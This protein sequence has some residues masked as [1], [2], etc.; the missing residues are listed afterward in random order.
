MEQEVEQLTRTLALVHPLVCAV[1]HFES[2]R[3][4]H[5]KTKEE[6]AERYNREQF[7][8][9]KKTIELAQR[10]ARRAHLR[11]SQLD[12]SPVNCKQGGAGRIRQDT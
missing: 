7:E 10:R 5:W 6:D 4:H 9:V 3:L 2:R 8:N 11:R 12:R 1:Q